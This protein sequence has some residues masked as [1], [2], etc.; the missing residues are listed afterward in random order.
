[1]AGADLMQRLQHQAGFLEIHADQRR[2][3]IFAHHDLHRL[4][5]LIGVPW[6][7]FS[8]LTPAFNTVFGFY[9]H[10]QRATV[11]ESTGCATVDFRYRKDQRV[12]IYGANF[13]HATLKGRVSFEMSSSFSTFWTVSISRSSFFSLNIWRVKFLAFSSSSDRLMGL[14]GV[15]LK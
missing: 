12:G 10:D 1:M 11:F 13:H 8:R 5:G 9:A 4:Q 15:P 14:C 7:A 2:T 3:K 6:P